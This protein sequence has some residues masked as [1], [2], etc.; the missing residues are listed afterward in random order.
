VNVPVTGSN[1]TTATTAGGATYVGATLLL[2]LLNAFAN[3][4]LRTGMPGWV[5][6]FVAPLV[7]ALVT[8]V[9]GYVAKN[10]AEMSAGRHRG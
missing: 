1:I 4:D 3:P 2:A 6:V 7:P 5:E 10:P 9:A 8:L